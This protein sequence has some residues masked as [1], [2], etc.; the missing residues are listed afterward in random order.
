M[1]DDDDFEDLSGLKSVV[2]EGPAISRDIVVAIHD[3]EIL[4]AAGE[5][6]DPLVGEPLEYDEVTIEHAGCTT[7]HRLL[8]V[9]IGTLYRPI[10]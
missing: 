3:N 7:R 9:Q 2:L 4:G 5:Y 6:G 1:V 8:S 10:G